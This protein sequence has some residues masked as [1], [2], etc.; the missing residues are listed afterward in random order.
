MEKGLGFAHFLSQVDNVGMGV[1]ALLLGL[2]V[3][4]WYLIVTKGINNYMAGRRSEAFL[5]RFWSATS[6]QEVS[7]T[8]K[9]NEPDNAFAQLARQALDTTADS[10]RQGLQNWLP[11]VAPVNS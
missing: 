4:S 7:A 5:T 6:L 11:Q 1:L 3:A 9:G 8:L 2:S 10:E